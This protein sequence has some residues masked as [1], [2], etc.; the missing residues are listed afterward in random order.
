MIIVVYLLY[1]ITLKV[2]MPVCLMSIYGHAFH[3]TPVDLCIIFQRKLYISCIMSRGNKIVS[4]CFKLIQTHQKLIWTRLHGDW[5]IWTRLHGDWLIWTR[6]HGD[7]L[8]WT[9]L[10]GD[11]LSLTRLRGDWA[12]WTLLRGDWLT[13]TLLRDD[14]LSHT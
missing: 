12:S 8:I 14:W 13:W 5:L 9:R 4:N 10:H 7:W 6:L 11:W 2:R 3:V 1:L